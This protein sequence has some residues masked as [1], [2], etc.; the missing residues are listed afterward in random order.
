MYFEVVHLG[1]ENN[2]VFATFFFYGR[3]PSFF[4]DSHD[5]PYTGAY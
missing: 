1:K 4:D 3:L 5:T 2:A